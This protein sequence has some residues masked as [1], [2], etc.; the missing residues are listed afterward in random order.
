MEGFMCR[1]LPKGPTPNDGVWA[2]RDLFET[3]AV[4]A[5]FRVFAAAVRLALRPKK[6]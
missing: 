2:D 6:K 1:A 3:L 5:A 4:P